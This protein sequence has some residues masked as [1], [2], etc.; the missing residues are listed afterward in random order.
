MEKGVSQVA[1]LVTRP[2]P[3][4]QIT[5]AALRARGYEV[6]LAPMLVTQPLAFQLDAGAN[7]RGIIVTSANA[8]RVIARH[9][10]L[11]TLLG[12]PVFA[13]GDHTA[14]TASETG[15]T[16]VISADGDAV[17]LRRLIVARSATP[18]KADTALLYLAA[19]ETSRDLAADLAS[20]K[21]QVATHKVYRTVAVTTVPAGT[22]AAFAAN[23]VDAVLHYSRRSALAFVAAVRAS[24]L[25][26]SA[27]AVPQCCLSDAV[28]GPLRDAGATR[29]AV[30]RL[31]RQDAL[32]AALERVAPPDSIDGR[33]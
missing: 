27:L 11:Q 4:N 17:A 22:E 5:A 23:T 8:L 13:V 19:D 16:D 15:F 7:Y 26:I 31:P 12:L 28:A 10:L 24:G 2:E 29:L 18:P 9:P 3:D 33:R 1:V 25:E 30:A 6:L 32:F 14:Q 20:A 21:I